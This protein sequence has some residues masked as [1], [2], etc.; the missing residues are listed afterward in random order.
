MKTNQEMVP[1]SGGGKTKWYGMVSK[2]N[3]SGK[4][5]NESKAM[6]KYIDKMRK[7]ERTAQHKTKKN[8]AV[9]HRTNAP[10]IRNF[11]VRRTTMYPSVQALL[12]ASRLTELDFNVELQDLREELDA[13]VVCMRS[14]LCNNS[15][16]P[17]IQTVSPRERLKL[18]QQEMLR[19]N[20][21]KAAI[22]LQAYLKYEEHLRN[23]K[24]DL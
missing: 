17:L 19:T 8:E 4:F 5:V 21:G 14:T 20:H 1:S 23:G 3:E 15:A 13:A 6:T 16:V 10:D 22:L 7:R 2:G 18:F 24:S 12:C 9:S 11:L